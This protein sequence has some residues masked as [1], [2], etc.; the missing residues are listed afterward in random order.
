MDTGRV[1]PAD[2]RTRPPVIADGRR[3]GAPGGS[4]RPAKP[5]PTAASD[6]EEE[7]HPAG[8]VSG[9]HLDLFA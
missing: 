1:V 4:N 3:R 8:D 7:T 9:G 2:G 6:D 5:V